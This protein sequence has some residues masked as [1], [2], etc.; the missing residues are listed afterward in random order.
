MGTI[1]REGHI[2]SISSCY[3]P[4]QEVV[5]LILLVC[6]L[7]LC[8]VFM[9]AYGIFCAHALKNRDAGFDF[10]KS[11]RFRQSN[12]LKINCR[13]KLQKVTFSTAAAGTSR[14][15]NFEAGITIR[16]VPFLP[17]SEVKLTVLSSSVATACNDIFHLSLESWHCLDWKT[18][19]GTLL[20]V[21][22]SLQGLAP[23]SEGEG[24][25]L[26]KSVEI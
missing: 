20:A 24:W 14:V 9:L 3:Q 1:S 7:F 17:T 15:V 25:L 8:M 6:S 5:P 13:M 19:V 2:S 16:S 26:Q 21:W 11:G 22:P 12:C 4:L 10:E 23:L 18:S